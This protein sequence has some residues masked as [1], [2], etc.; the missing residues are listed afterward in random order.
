MLF[1][2]LIIFVCWLGSC[3]AQQNSPGMLASN[4]DSNSLLWEITGKGLQKPS[5]LFGTFHMMCSSDIHFSE[6]LKT[7]LISTNEV[8]FEMDLDDLSEMMSALF[9]MNMQHGQTLKDLYDSANY[10]KVQRFFQDTLLLPF[11][12]LQRMKPAFL[13]S[14]LFTKMLPCS[15]LSGVDEELL[16][17]AAANKKQV[18]GF[19]TM[20]FQ[21]AVF[22]SIPYQ[23]QAG[24]LLQSIDSLQWG[25]VKFQR[26]LDTYKRQQLDSLEVLL[27]EDNGLDA[28][29]EELLL[30]SRN[31]NWVVKLNTILK[32]QAIFVAVGAAHLVGKNGLL[33]LLRIEGYGLRPIWNR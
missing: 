1:L 10:V 19:E 33:S 15:Q 4:K 25:K 20:A 21:A 8:Y 9:L 2:I 18:R 22:D 30:N 7:A 28:M 32:S 24:S 14:M 23:L 29:N 16:K 31:R 11:V 3:N 5:Y 6:N 27:Q 12:A 13:E 17:I 26:M